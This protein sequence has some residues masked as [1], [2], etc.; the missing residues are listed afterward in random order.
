MAAPTRLRSHLSTRE[1]DVSGPSRS[2]TLKSPNTTSSCFV[3]LC[4][5]SEQRFDQVHL[6]QQSANLEAQEYHLDQSKHPFTKAAL[7]VAGLKA[8]ACNGLTAWFCEDWQQ[9]LHYR[10][11]LH[12]VNLQQPDAGL[13]NPAALQNRDSLVGA[14]TRRE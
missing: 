8:V 5:T 3:L 13:A 11:C 12:P 6:P 10:S 2:A 1:A 14:K 4:G 9:G 7:Q